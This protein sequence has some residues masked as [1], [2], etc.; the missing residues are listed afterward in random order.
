V[1]RDATLHLLLRRFAALSSND[2]DH[3]LGL[4]SQDEREALLSACGE[5]AGPALSPGLAGLIDDCRANNIPPAITRQAAS[6]LL[7]SCDAA[8]GSRPIEQALDRLFAR[9]HRW[10][11]RSARKASAQ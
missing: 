7:A 8:T 5:P 10:D 2:R 6:A 4:L 1:T 9:R 3:V 11:A